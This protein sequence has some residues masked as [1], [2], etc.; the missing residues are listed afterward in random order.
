L[1]RTFAFTITLKLTG[2]PSSR[3]IIYR[4][5]EVLVMENPNGM[6]Y[7][8]LG[9]MG[10][11]VW[12]LFVALMVVLRQLEHATTQ[13]AMLQA[14]GERGGCGCGALLTMAV[15]LIGIVLLVGMLIR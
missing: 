5:K 1:F 13:L 3:R 11:G 7:L 14:Q 15:L 2:P 8:A 12:F 9:A 6:L 10:L 4:G